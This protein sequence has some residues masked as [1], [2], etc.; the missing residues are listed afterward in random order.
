MLRDTL[1]AAALSG[2]FA[3]LMLTLVQAV[4]VTPLIQEAET[5]ESVGNTHP[6]GVE[7]HEHEH[8]HGDAEEWEPADGWQRTSFTL[9][10]NLVMGLGYGLLLMGVYSLWRQPGGLWS[11]VA[12]GVAGFIV[13]FVAPSL[14]LPPELPGTVAAPVQERQLWWAMTAL[15][16]GGALL[17]LFSSPFSWLKAVTAVAMLVTPHVFV[18]A[19]TPEVH[20]ALAPEFLQHRFQMATTV[21]NA[22][23]WLLLGAASSLAFHKLMSSHGRLSEA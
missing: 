18:A 10:A 12:F 5:Y 3:A 9:A 23:F 22:V 17:L 8:D 2:L 6:Q 21:A 16:T 19:P 14:G 20:A 15:L 4:W 11:G 1:L 7:S 13:F